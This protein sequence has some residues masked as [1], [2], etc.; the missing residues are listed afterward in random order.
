MPL[1]VFDISVVFTRLIVSF[2]VGALIGL[3]RERHQRPAG[4]RTHVLVCVASAV[5][6][7]ISI[8]AAGAQY[9]PGRIAAQ[10]VTGIGFLGAG[11]IM[12]HGSTV[13]GLT[14]AASLWMTAA[15]GMAIG[16]GCYVLAVIAAALSFLALTFL[17]VLE[18]YLVEKPSD[19]RVAISA[20]PGKDP[21]PQIL[22]LARTAGARI[23]RIRLG[24]ETL[25]EGL[26]FLLTVE[27]PSALTLE[28]LIDML[29]AVE[30]VRDVEALS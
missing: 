18:E 5:F 10:I 29:K 26:Y 15:L 16:F 4:L 8:Y 27:L 11:T 17:K 2:F 22:V 6:A 9:D 28:A 3:E 25:E 20:L 19:L 21:L 23:S 30:G 7:M 14:T 12:R 1:N 13:K 24:P